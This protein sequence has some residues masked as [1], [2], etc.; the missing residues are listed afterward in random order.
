MTSMTTA[1][2]ASQII[3]EALK[4]LNAVREHAKTSKDSDLK[5]HISTLYDNLLSVKEA[6]LRLTE[7]NTDLKRQIEEK[8]SVRRDSSSGLIYKG[9]D[10]APLCPKCY[11]TENKSV[12]LDPAYRSQGTGWVSRFCRACG[13]TYYER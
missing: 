5:E 6:V 9:N 8:Q 11:Q 13:E 10:P 1:V 12:H 7:E 2:A 3:S 4:A